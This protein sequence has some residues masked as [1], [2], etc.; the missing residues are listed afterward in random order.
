MTAFAAVLMS[1][2]Q[3]SNPE[4]LVPETKTGVPMTIQASFDAPAGTKVILDYDENDKSLKGSWDQNEAITVVSFGN[5]GITAVDKFYSDGERG[6][7][8]AEFT[9]TWTGNEGDKIICL[10]PDIDSFAGQSIFE[11]VSW[12]SP[13]IYM[14]NLSTPLGP[15]QDDD[16]GAVSDVDLMLGEVTLS[17]NV[18]HVNLEHLIAVFRIEVTLKN[19]PYNVEPDGPSMQSINTIRIKCVNPANADPDAD[20]P[21]FVRETGLNVMTYS[22]TGKPFA[23]DYE[24]RPLDY[25]L[26]DSGNNSELNMEFGEVVKTFF[27]PVRFYHDLEAGYEL[28]FQFGGTYYDYDER[29]FKSI[30]VFPGC[31]K[32]KTITSKL[33]LENG[34]VYCFRVT[35]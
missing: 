29:C 9:G 34:K 17:G 19:L 5:N 24:K 18:A 1:S 7:K 14:R 33:P 26:L 35:I 13:T 15:L 28:H 20:D 11:G 30:D 23:D 2:C 16:T 27:V 10:Y 31:D 25:Y 22:Y 6:R 21:V 8:K 12:C 3:E 4:T 32:S